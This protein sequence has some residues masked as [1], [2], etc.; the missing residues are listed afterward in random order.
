MA[1]EAEREVMGL[2]LTTNAEVVSG[3]L[4]G[5]GRP[6]GYPVLAAVAAT[7][8][9]SLIVDDVLHALVD[10]ARAEGRTWQEIGD[11]LRVS[12]QA[13]FQRFGAA[14]PVPEIEAKTI[15]PVGGAAERALEILEHEAHGRW[16]DVRAAFDARMLQGLPVEQLS[17]AWTQTQCMVG[18]FREFGLPAVRMVGAY[19]VVDI[20][21]RFEKGAMK[22]RVALNHDGQVSGFFL[23]TPEAP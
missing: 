15:T 21:M 9:L 13:A 11:V 23:L 17:S 3:V 18:D 20:P 1:S 14:V 10:Q 7:R 4:R 19:T 22:G 2:L 16:E 5:V 8:S 6:D 12:R